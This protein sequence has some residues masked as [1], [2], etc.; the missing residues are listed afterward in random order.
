MPFNQSL[1]NQDPAPEIPAGVAEG[2]KEE[3]K[4]KP[5]VADTQVEKDAL[6]VAPDLDVPTGVLSVIVHQI[7]NREHFTSLCMRVR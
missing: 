7:N 4:E 6:T 3:M 2:T 1:S 5:T